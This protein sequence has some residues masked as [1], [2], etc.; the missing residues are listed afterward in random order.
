MKG[1][2]KERMKF[3]RKIIKWKGFFYSIKRKK[4]K[5]KKVKFKRKKKK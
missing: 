1:K 3:E 2:I 5:D 4:N